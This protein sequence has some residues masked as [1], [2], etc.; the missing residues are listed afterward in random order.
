MLVISRKRRERLVL[1]DTETGVRLTVTVAEIRGGSVRLGVEAP[2]RFKIHREEVL[3]EIER[4][5]SAAPA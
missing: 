1:I 2:S 4:V 5:S 3:A